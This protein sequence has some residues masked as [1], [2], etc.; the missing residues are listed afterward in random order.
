MNVKNNKS[1]LLGEISKTREFLTRLDQH[2]RVFLETDYKLL[3]K[4]NSSA[5][6]IAEI[7][8]DFYT[9]IE[10]LFL[11]IS[12]FFENDL[13]PDQWHKD[14]LHKMTLE[15]ADIRR[16]VISEETFDLLSEFLKFRHFRRYYFEFEY[17]WDKIE[18][19]QKKY[20]RVKPLIG[21]DLDAFSAFLKQLL[22]KN[23]EQAQ[24]N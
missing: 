9:C 13:C 16:R 7:L 15:V 1:V 4:K 23:S 3:G 19:L 20:S 8:S 22:E 2:Y 6:V 14:L 12:Q 18:Y 17:D 24:Q 21:Q 11:R 5:V 10:T